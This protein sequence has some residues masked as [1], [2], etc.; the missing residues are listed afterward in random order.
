MIKESVLAS[1][2]EDRPLTVWTST[3]R[4]TI[5]T[6]RHLPKEYHRLQWKALDE[7]DAGVCDGLTYQEIAD[8]Y[9]ED[10]KSRDED[11]FSYRY[12]LRPHHTPLCRFDGA[13]TLAGL[14]QDPVRTPSDLSQ[15]GK[16]KKKG[17]G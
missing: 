10:F 2:G 6:A 12:E 5:A 15:G 1:V 4:R 8:R 14:R 7:L 9:P 13:R 11:K 3:L 16:R 17:T